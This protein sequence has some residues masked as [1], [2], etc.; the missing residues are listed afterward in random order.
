MGNGTE[1]LFIDAWAWLIFIGIGLLLVLLELLLGIDTGFDLV[2]IGS[3]F[4]LGGLI[5]L[6]FNSW[7]LTLV[8][9]AAI[10]ILYVLLGRRYI[11]RRIVV[12]SSLSNVDTIIGKQGVVRKPISPVADGRVLVEQQDWR[13]RAEEKIAEGEI[14]IV[15]DVRGV[16]LTVKKAGDSG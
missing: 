3:A 7:V 12:K 10:C 14:I 6:P 15:Q 16:T 2:F 5:T 13:A 9:S 11:H 4:V 8:V 1:L